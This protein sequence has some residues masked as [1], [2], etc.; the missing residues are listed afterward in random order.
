[1]N[2]YDL[3][4]ERLRGHWIKGTLDDDDGNVCSLGALQVV[5]G[6]LTSPDYYASAER[7]SKIVVDGYPDRLTYDDDDEQMGLHPVAQF[8]DHPDTT[9]EDVLLAFKQASYEYD[10]AHKSV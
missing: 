8:N 1:M 2:I 6:G 7:L 3:A 5:T 10:E 9:E 4:A